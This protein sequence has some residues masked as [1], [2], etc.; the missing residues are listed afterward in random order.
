MN[1]THDELSFREY[2]G[3]VIMVTH[4]ERLVRRTDCSLWVV[5]NQVRF[6]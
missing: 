5:E 6:F 1:L 3:G 4:D 2:G